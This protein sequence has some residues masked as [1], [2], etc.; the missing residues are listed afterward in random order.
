MERNDCPAAVPAFQILNWDSLIDT[1]LLHFFEFQGEFQSDKSLF[2]R[3]AEVTMSRGAS[4]DGIAS[5][6]TLSFSVLLH[7]P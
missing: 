1:I 7:N 2:F 4:F 6:L 3:L 5:P